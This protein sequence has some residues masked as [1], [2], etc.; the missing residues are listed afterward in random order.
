V[1]DLRV[2][3]VALPHD[4]ADD[5]ANEVRRAKARDPSVWARWHDQHY[6]FVYRDAYARLR[7]Q[8]DAE[9]VASQV[10]LEAIKGIDRYHHRGRPVLAWFYGIAQNLISHRYR[11]YRRSTSLSAL[12]KQVEDLGVAVSGEHDLDRIV[13]AGALDRL[14][15]EHREVL[16]LRFIVDLPTR[17]VAQVIG[18][19]EAATYS[20]QVRALSAMQALLTE[21]KVSQRGRKTE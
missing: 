3:G 2:T 11:E 5:S 8:Q 10:F 15:P 4:V 13:L 21:K 18:K 14:K 16:L 1:V 6:V 9:D 7:T 12:G 20:L 17:Q 19:S